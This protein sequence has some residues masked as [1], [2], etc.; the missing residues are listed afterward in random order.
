MDD[1]ILI[2]IISAS[3]ALVGSFIPTIFTYFK[4]KDQFQFELKKDLLANQKSVYDGILIALQNM[5]NNQGNEEFEALQKASIKLAI[6]GDNNSAKA[7]NEYY[8]EVTKSGRNARIPLTK[9]EHKEYQEKIIN[10]IRQNL[11]LN[12]LDSFE[13]VGFRPDKN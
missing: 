3:S 8:N 1:K 2:A 12:K 10:G 9:E 5:I 4:T 11:G 6:Y 7:M 13:I